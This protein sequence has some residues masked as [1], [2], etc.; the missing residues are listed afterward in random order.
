MNKEIARILFPVYALLKRIEESRMI[1]EEWYVKVS[2]GPAL[3]IA[4]LALIFVGVRQKGISNTILFNEILFSAYFRCYE[5]MAVVYGPDERIFFFFDPEV[6]KPVKEF[7]DN[8]EKEVF[9][10]VAITAFV[11]GYI[12]TYILSIS[13][14]LISTTTALYAQDNALLQKLGIFR[15]NTQNT[16][17]ETILYL[18]IFVVMFVLLGYA[19]EYIWAAVFSAMGSL[20]L[21]VT[22]ECFY[23]L[24][25]GMTAFFDEDEPFLTIS[26]EN[27]TILYLISLFTLGM[28]SQL[29]LLK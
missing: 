24:K 25:T 3:V 8:H 18:V 9:L 2:L 28:V 14:F 22:L 16:T 10:T 7:L 11:M 4:F 20:S 26:P 13:R 5:K 21:L 6:L 23:G 17:I 12:S 29:I 19:L 15:E 1:S 27:P